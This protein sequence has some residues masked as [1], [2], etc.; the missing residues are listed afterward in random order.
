MNVNTVKEK[1]YFV[2]GSF[3]FESVL[4]ET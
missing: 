1:H 2:L 3:V 4:S